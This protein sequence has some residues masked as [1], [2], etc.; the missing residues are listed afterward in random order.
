MDHAELIAAA[1]IADRWGWHDRAI[2]TVA[3][4]ERY[5]DLGLR[6]P[7]AHRDA[8]VRQARARGLDSAW[9]YG[10]LRQESAFMA[11]ARSSAGALGLM[12]LMPAT[13][14]LVA[15][16]INYP[17]RSDYELLE[18]ETNIR[19]GTSYLRMVLDQLGDQPVLATAAY[20]A[21]PGRVKRWT[22][23]RGHLP[24]DMWIET[25]PFRETRDYLQRV[26][27]YTAIYE[28]RLGQEPTR[29]SERLGL[30][31]MTAEGAGGGTGQVSQRRPAEGSGP[32]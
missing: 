18:P 29:L 2:L 32:G 22:A 31:V 13:A 27:A 28:W 23:E 24:M 3:K 19:F 7:L 20:N 9:V 16:R 30:R 21:G 11:D 17:L 15:R 25:V 12:Q 10:V 4:A 6:F 14:K 1:L 8:V 26:L 5:D